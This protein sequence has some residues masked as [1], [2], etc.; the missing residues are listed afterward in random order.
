M[1]IGAKIVLNASAAAAREGLAGLAGGTWMLSVPQRRVARG[2]HPAGSALPCP[3]GPG[4][5]GSVAVVFGDLAAAGCADVVV[6]PV[7]WESL[8]PGD[9]FTVLLDA[10]ITLD[11]VCGQETGVLTLAGVCRL[12]GTLSADSHEHART[13]ITEA[14]GAFITSV[15]D[16][17]TGSAIPRRVHKP[18]GPAM[19][20]LHELPGMA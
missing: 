3:A 19:T 10:D 8:E 18:A 1:I 12:S 17:V 13:Q 6:L 11:R 15:A 5:T 7:R 4:R 9:E 16:F 14:A 2:G 20:W